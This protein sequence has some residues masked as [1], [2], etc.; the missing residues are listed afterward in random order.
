MC[1][2]NSLLNMG[3]ITSK[4]LAKDYDVVEVIKTGEFSTVYMVVNKKNNDKK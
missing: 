1:Y 2:T 3:I 4:R